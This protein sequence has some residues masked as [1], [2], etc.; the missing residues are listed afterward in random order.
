ML[1]KVERIKKKKKNQTVKNNSNKD[2]IIAALKK[3]LRSD[4]LNKLI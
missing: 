2:Y 4:T 3:A 1:W